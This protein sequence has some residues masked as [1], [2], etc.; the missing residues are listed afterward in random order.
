MGTVVGNFND[1]VSRARHYKVKVISRKRKPIQYIVGILSYALFIL[2][3][4]IGVT[5]L[6]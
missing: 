6:V 2:L 3:L 1:V 4:L 5:L